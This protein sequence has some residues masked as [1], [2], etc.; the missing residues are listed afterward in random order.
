MTHMNFK[1]K[2]SDVT[3]GK[4][5]PCCQSNSVKLISECVNPQGVRFLATS[6]CE[7]CGHV[8][9]S[10]VPSE[11]WFNHAFQIRHEEQQKTGFNPLNPEIEKQRYERYHAIGHFLSKRFGIEKNALLD[12]GCGPGTGLD[13]FNDLG[14]DVVGVD[15]DE[16][17]ARFAIEKGHE[18]HLGE[19]STFITEQKFDFITLIHSLEHFQNPEFF[20]RKAL[21]HAHEHTLFYVEVPEVLDHVLDWNDSLYL[22]HISNFNA[23]SLENLAARCGWDLL[24][25]V[26][27]Y[28]E[29][30]LHKGHLA[31]VFRPRLSTVP[32]SVKS[33]NDHQVNEIVSRY[34]QG[35][36]DVRKDFPMI[37]KVK[38]VNDISLGYK[39]IKELKKDVHDN[40]ANRSITRTGDNTYYVS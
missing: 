20:L 21:E 7:N 23:T 31:M 17:R 14:F 5:C 36:P 37:I 13:A 19:F 4:E 30:E 26:N 40:Y 33:L 16:S 11:S 35:V 1:I 29:S 9:R 2:E 24:E 25:Q 32:N 10:R 22:A 8:F 15:P 12:V 6:I 27:P 38:E 3:I 39:G 34:Y 18:I 28:M